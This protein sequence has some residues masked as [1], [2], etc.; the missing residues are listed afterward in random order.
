[1]ATN[2][3]REPDSSEDSN[4]CMLDFADHDLSFSFC[5]TSMPPTPEKVLDDV[6]NSTPTKSSRLPKPVLKQWNKMSLTKSGRQALQAPQIM[7]LAIRKG[8]TGGHAA[9]RLPMSV[10]GKRNIGR[11]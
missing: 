2:L 8:S 4:W 10:K 5:D 9:T 3:D 7:S 6:D 1:M 11:A